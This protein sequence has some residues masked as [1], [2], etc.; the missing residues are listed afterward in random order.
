MLIDVLELV[1]GGLPML[2]RAQKV[3]EEHYLSR[4][5]GRRLVWYS[6][7]ET[8]MLKARY[9]GGDKDLQVSM[10]Q[11]AVLMLFN[12]HDEL[13]YREIRDILKLPDDELRR[14]LQSLALGKVRACPLGN[15]MGSVFRGFGEGSCSPV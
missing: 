3:F 12:E 13:T 15:L 8:C 9:P 1:C 6:M 2:C 10:H 14:T 11:A 4:T 5:S 7:L